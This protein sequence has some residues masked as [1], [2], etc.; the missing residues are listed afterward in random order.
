[1]DGKTL[2]LEVLRLEG[3]SFWLAPHP[4]PGNPESISEGADYGG[5]DEERAG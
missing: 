2:V 1:M 5:Y 4:R 3:R